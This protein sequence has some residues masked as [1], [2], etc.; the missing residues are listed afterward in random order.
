M[1]KRSEIQ[2]KLGKKLTDALQEA[3]WECT[4]L[5]RTSSLTKQGVGGEAMGCSVS[6]KHRRQET[7]DCWQFPDRSPGSHGCHTVAGQG[8]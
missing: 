1:L 3:L 2:N 5:D 7:K 8:T 6:N 4:H